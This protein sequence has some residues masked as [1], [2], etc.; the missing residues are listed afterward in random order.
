VLREQGNR[1]SPV[2]CLDRSGQLT[3]QPPSTAKHSRRNAPQAS[4]DPRPLTTDD[5]PTIIREVC[6]NLSKKPTENVW[7]VQTTATDEDRS[8]RV[9]QAGKPTD[10]THHR[11]TTTPTIRDT[12]IAWWMLMRTMWLITVSIS[13]ALL[14]THYNYTREFICIAC[15]YISALLL[16]GQANLPSCYVNKYNQLLLFF[17]AL[18]LPSRD[19]LRHV[20]ELSKYSDDMPA[21]D[22]ASTD[23]FLLLKLING[24]L[25]LFCTS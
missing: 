9:N 8:R 4:S 21:T 11:V 13:C 2:L 1:L 23:K 15:Q 6:S 24:G 10:R 17:S 18:A 3:V 5:L 20:R 16:A 19:Q 7:D 22:S 25:Q 14:I 12:Q